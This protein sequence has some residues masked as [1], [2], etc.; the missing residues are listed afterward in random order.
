MLRFTHENTFIS[1]IDLNFLLFVFPN[2]FPCNSQFEEAVAE[3]KA[4]SGSTANP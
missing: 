1:A 2:F 3:L 4:A